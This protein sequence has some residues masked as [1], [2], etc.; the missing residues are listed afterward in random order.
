MELRGKDTPVMIEW[1]IRHRVVVM[2]SHSMETDPSA[3]LDK[4]GQHVL[5]IQEASTYLLAFD[6][7]PS[8][9]VLS[10]YMSQSV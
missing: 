2:E 9:P 4:I 7:T 6:P 5:S 8:K 1:H 3:H 10:A